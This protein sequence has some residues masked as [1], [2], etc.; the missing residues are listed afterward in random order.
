MTDR[1]DPH[2]AALERRL[3]SAAPPS[4]SPNLRRRVLSSIDDVLHEK[5]PT[6]KSRWFAKPTSTLFEDLVV[7]ALF[8]TA[9]AA[10][11]AV[12]A[13]S[14]ASVSAL[15]TPISLHERARIAGV[16]NETFDLLIAESSDGSAAMRTSPAG[17]IPADHDTLRVRDTHRILRETP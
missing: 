15:A 11:V 1:L 10:A 9:L 8:P 2:L 14:V 16:G 7:N 13:L 5:V 12:L 17:S 3:E 4:A 6:S